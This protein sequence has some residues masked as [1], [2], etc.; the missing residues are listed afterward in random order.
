MKETEKAWLAGLF[1]GEGSVWS[2]WPKRSN[3]ISVEIK[4]T[5]KPT[6]EKVQELFPGRFVV[7]HLSFNGISKRTQWKWTLETNKAVK[8]L[9]EILPYLVTKHAQV[10]IA[11]ELAGTQCKSSKLTNE[12]RQKR[13]ILAEKLR[14]LKGEFWNN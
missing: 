3:L 9:I 7:G 12:K 11:L 14:L 6:L 4:M 13:N 1:D 10:V 2:R 5:H 8:F